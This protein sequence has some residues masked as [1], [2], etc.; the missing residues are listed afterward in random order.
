MCTR[1]VKQSCPLSPILFNLAIE[2]LLQG[3]EDLD[4][5]YQFEELQLKVI[6]YANNLCLVISDQKGM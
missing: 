6:A 2:Q 4:V 5:G 3:L 1:G